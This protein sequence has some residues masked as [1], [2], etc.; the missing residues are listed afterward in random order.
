MTKTIEA[1]SELFP[2]GVRETRSLPFRE[3]ELRD[4][5]DGTGGTMLA[6]EG[7]ACVTDVGFEMWDM[8]GSFTEFVRRGAFT[9]TLSE[10]ADVAFLVNHEGVT[11]ARTKSETL[12]LAEDDTGLH[13]EA[14]LDPASPAVQVI[15]SAMERGDMDEMSFAFRVTKQEWSPD[16]EQ[17]DILEVNLD[18]GDVSL[19]NYGANPFT[20][21]GLRSIAREARRRGVVGSE[22]YLEALREVR[23]GK[24]LSTATMET[25]QQVVH[26]ISGADG[27]G[28]EAHVLLSDLMGVPNADE[29]ESKSYPLSLARARFEALVLAS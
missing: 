6:F 23:A 26:L 4:K 18:K 22:R 14:G 12:R 8:F 28:D 3:V 9:K 27:D 5:P 24:T 20:S 13:S 21:G 17:R 10:G 19:V 29:S 2:T 7:Y 16:Y 15:R 11:L 25:L 1:R